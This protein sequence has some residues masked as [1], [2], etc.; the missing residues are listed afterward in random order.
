[1]QGIS[2]PGRDERRNLSL[3]FKR[4]SPLFHIGLLH[5]NVGTDT[6]HESYAPCNLNDLLKPEMDYWALG[7]VH[8]Q[9]VL[10]PSFPCIVYPGNTQGRHIRETGE[11][12][13]FLVTVSDGK[14]IDLEFHPTDI[15]RW[16]IREL[17]ITDLN[18]EQDII[19][20]FENTCDEVVDV[21]E[22]RHAIIRVIFKGRGPLYHRLRDSNRVDDLLDGFREIGVSY[23]PSIWVERLLMDVRPEWD[24]NEWM[25]NPDFVGELLRYAHE[26]LENGGFEEYSKEELP[27][28]FEDSRVRRHIPFPEGQRLTA[29]IKQAAEMCADALHEEENP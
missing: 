8:R 22:G 28:L 21:A 14:V 15:F 7:H 13:C 9:S 17:R 12:G 5:A 27:G 16:M 20:A 24:L 3:L 1:V 2:Y 18:S 23:T 11:K 6:G 26:L 4:T 25:T 10:S 29:L 19:H